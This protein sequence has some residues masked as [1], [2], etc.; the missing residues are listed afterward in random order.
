MREAEN[1]YS[2]DF[3]WEQL[4]QDVENDPSLL[5]HFTPYSNPAT[6]TQDLDARSS[7][8]SSYSSCL[9]KQDSEAWN[10]FHTRHSTG[11][12]FKVSQFI[13]IF[14]FS[15]ICVKIWNLDLDYNFWDV[16]A[17]NAKW[18]I[19]NFHFCYFYPQLR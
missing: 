16:L 18:A 2:K 13:C 3:E 9:P 8:S 11:K 15:S 1:Y 12:F 4:K 10:K 6:G 17:S 7:S 14:V 19:S 5:Y